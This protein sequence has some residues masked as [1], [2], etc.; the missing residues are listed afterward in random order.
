MSSPAVLV[1]RTAWMIL[2]GW[3]PVKAGDK[4]ALLQGV[5]EGVTFRDARTWVDT[6]MD[7]TEIYLDAD[8][9]ARLLVRRVVRSP[10]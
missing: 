8:E 2:K 7:G 9:D 4:E 10:E 1:P 6:G 3:P 5:A